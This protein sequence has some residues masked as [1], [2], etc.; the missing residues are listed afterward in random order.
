MTVLFQ[1]CSLAF[2]RCET[3]DGTIRTGHYYQRTT[4]VWVCVNCGLPR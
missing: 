3:L 2:D 4:G 1:D